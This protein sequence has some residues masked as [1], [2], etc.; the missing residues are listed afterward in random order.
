MMN[1]S[2]QMNPMTGDMDIV[3]EQGEETTLLNQLNSMSYQDRDKFLKRL[4]L[5]RRSIYDPL[6][7]ST[8]AYQINL[9]LGR[10]NNERMYTL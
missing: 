7:D 5:D 10:L 1:P 6:P 4:S 3:T 9:L 2:G 8:E